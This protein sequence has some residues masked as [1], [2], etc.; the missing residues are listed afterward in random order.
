[1]TDQSTDLFV[2]A[3]LI[4]HNAKVTTQDLAQPQASALAVKRGRI[5]AVGSD[6]EILSLKDGDTRLID[7]GGRRLIPGLN[8]V[9][10]HVLNERGYTYNVRWEGVPTLR[11]VSAAMAC[12]P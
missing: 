9:H 7:A 8:D 11:Q 10:L 3:D 2:G 6:S 4:V 5:Y 12:C 1:M